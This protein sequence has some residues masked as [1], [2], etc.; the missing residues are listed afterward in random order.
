MNETT[1]ATSGP[2]AHCSIL[3]LDDIQERYGI[4]R[5]KATE[6][7]ATDGFPKSVVPGMHRY[8][9]AALEA[10]AMAHALRGTLGPVFTH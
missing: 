9:L 10:W 4:G 3:D 1:P 5:T 8:P 7:V 6:F 2:H